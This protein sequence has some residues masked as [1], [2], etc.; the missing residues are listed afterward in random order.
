MRKKILIPILLA[1]TAMSLTGCGRKISE[2]IIPSELAT[3]LYTSTPDDGIDQTKNLNIDAIVGDEI[4]NK[5]DGTITVPV[6]ATVTDRSIYTGQ[7]EVIYGKTDDPGDKDGYKIQ[8]VKYINYDEWDIQ[9]V[10]PL[11]ADMVKLAILD[12]DTMIFAGSPTKLTADNVTNVAFTNLQASEDEKEIATDVTLDVVEEVVTYHVQASLK[13]VHTINGYKIEES[14]VS[15]YDV[16][17]NE[18][19]TF[20]V[21][22]EDLIKMLENSAMKVGD[23]SVDL[24]NVTEVLSREDEFDPARLSMTIITKMQIENKFY[25]ASANVYY[26]YKL[27]SKKEYWQLDE[28]TADSFKVEE[29]TGLKGLFKGKIGNTVTECEVGNSKND[30]SF[31]AVLM[32]SD[33]TEME[34]TG[35]IDPENLTVSMQEEDGTLKLKGV[36]SAD[37]EAFK[38]QYGKKSTWWFQTEDG[39]NKTTEKKEKKD[40]YSMEKDDYTPANIEEEDGVSDN[41]V[42]KASRTSSV[43][44]NDRVTSDELKESENSTTKIIKGERTISETVGDNVNEIIEY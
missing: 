23:Q 1:A 39:R 2:A 43:S 20:T 42:K 26:V 12:K 4:Q 38:G 8:D 29:W 22:D 18:A 35:K 44:E 34:M 24:A 14:N 25:K 7:F 13:F 31:T 3:Y 28:Y 30:G 10:A 5:E 19:Y 15:H 9:P 37:I 21:S 41:N 6:N 27:D 32:Y 33:K 16:E 40:S 36:F 17:L 11:D